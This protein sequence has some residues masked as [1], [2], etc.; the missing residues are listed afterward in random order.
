MKK[1]TLADWLNIFKQI[2]WRM[3]RRDYLEVVQN[4]V[5][6]ED[7]LSV[8]QFLILRRIRHYHVNEQFG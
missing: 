7:Q 8:K 4:V 3:F 5:L 2:F 1:L 6:Q